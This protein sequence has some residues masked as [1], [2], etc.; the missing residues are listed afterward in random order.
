MP[1]NK[2]NNPYRES[3]WPRDPYQWADEVGVK[4]KQS[5][6]VQLQRNEVL[7]MQGPMPDDYTEQARKLSPHLRQPKGED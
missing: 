1:S 7:D 4:S 3:P 6:K 2:A 5:G